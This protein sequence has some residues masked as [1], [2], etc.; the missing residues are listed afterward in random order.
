[1]C[2]AGVAATPP[3]EHSVSGGEVLGV[4]GQKVCQDENSSQV[5]CG[6]PVPGTERGDAFLLFNATV[7]QVGSQLELQ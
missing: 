2:G 4:P 1:M 5:P 3:Q 7:H 6:P